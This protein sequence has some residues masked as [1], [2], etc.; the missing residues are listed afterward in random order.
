MVADT[1][2]YLTAHGRRVF[3]DAEHFFDGYASD[4]GYAL[5]VLRAAGDAGADLAVLCDTNGGMLPDDVA[6]IVADVAD[7]T[8]LRLGIHCHNDTGCAVA[9]TLA[10]VDVGATH[11]QGTLN[12]YGERTGNCGVR[13]PLYD[14]C[15]RPPA[16]EMLVQQHGR[17]TDL[18]S[19]RLPA[20]LKEDVGFGHGQF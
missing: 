5:D 19:A 2:A 14:Y 1:V 10:A 6:S 20:H 18:L 7:A 16:R 17:S 11:V 12:G 8:G 4:R 3:L 9:N 13:V 15:Q